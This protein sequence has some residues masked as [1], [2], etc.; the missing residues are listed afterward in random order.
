MSHYEGRGREDKA[1][2]SFPRP[3]FSREAR[4]FEYAFF[5][6][7]SLL[8]SYYFYIVF[9]YFIY[10]LMV[11][12]YFALSHFFS[13]FSLVCF[14]WYLE[15]VANC[16]WNLSPITSST[17]N[18]LFICRLSRLWILSCI[19]NVSILSP[20]YNLSSSMHQFTIYLLSRTKYRK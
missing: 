18:R 19:E 10:F 6:S 12:V 15:N 5:F 9:R 2:V 7:P 13:Y 17:F 8:F 11:I 16:A 1:I 20:L 14:E 4:A 3:P